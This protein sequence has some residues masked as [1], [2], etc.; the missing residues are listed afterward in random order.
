[1]E[2]SNLISCG[3]ILNVGVVYNGLNMHNYCINH[4][5]D[6][7][8]RQNVARSIMSVLAYILVT[9]DILTRFIE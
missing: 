2:R 9:F 1:M 4:K 6:I 5:R 8:T 3:H 7:Q